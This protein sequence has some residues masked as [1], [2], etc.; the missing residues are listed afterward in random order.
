MVDADGELVIQRIRRG[1][2]AVALDRYALKRPDPK[3]LLLGF[4]AFD[5]DMIRE[6][7]IRLAAALR[8]RNVEG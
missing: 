4:A 1:I 5:E 8:R 7:V 6:V 2:E 3:G